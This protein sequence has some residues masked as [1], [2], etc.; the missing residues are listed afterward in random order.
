MWF[1][2]RV[3][4]GLGIG[5]IKRGWSRVVGYVS[6]MGVWGVGSPIWGSSAKRALWSLNSVFIAVVVVSG[7]WRV[8][9]GMR[10]SQWFRGVLFGV[11]VGVCGSPKC[12]SCV[13]VMRSARGL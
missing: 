12:W 4:R 9:V 2:R 1:D 8:A 3:G 6:T 11:Y 5:S 13:S 10:I 7:G